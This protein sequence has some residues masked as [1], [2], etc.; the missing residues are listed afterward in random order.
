MQNNGARQLEISLHKER[1]W[2][3]L[4]QHNHGGGG[5][6]HKVWDHFLSLGCIMMSLSVLHENQ[7]NV[8]EINEFNSRVRFLQRSKVTMTILSKHLIK[9]SLCHRGAVMQP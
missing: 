3:E 8:C 7:K 9:I 1:R 5:F 4:Q 6:R 2:W